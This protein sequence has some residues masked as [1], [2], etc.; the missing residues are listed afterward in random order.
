[1]SSTMLGIVVIPPY[2][3]LDW[4]TLHHVEAIDHPEMRPPSRLL[5]VDIFGGVKFADSKEV[6]KQL[7]GLQSLT[8][9]TL[10]RCCSSRL[11]VY[12]NHKANLD[13]ITRYHKAEIVRVS[14]VSRSRYYRIRYMNIM[15]D[16]RKRNI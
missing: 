6:Y 5:S 12:S 2:Y 7:Y 1:M 13:R 8:S 9:Y 11:R 4:R 16:Y 14:G 3:E 15:Q 10:Y